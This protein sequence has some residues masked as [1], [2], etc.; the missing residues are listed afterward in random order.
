MTRNHTDTERLDWLIGNGASIS[1]SYGEGDAETPIWWVEWDTV[2]SDGSRFAKDKSL[3]KAI[4]K[5]MNATT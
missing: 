1:D 2:E 4:D 5:A 3:R